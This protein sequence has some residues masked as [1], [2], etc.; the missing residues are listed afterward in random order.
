M[1]AL[2]STA[3]T[4]GITTAACLTGMIASIS[5]IGIPVIRLASP[6]VAVRQWS[7]AYAL[8]KAI[9]PPLAITSA[10][11]FGYMS[12]ASRQALPLQS[13]ELGSPMLLYAI[14]AA[15]IP[16]II[17]YTLSVMDPGANNRLKL[18]AKEAERSSKSME[19]IKDEVQELLGIWAGMNYVRAA[20]VG[21]GAVLGAIAT[22]AM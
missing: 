6:G 1:S 15:L 17:P 9:A 22:I 20:A 18:L 2:I 21:A 14:A 13:S 11:C 19:S 7:K 10:A 5:Y 4:V 16:C 3:Q 12:Y 8:G